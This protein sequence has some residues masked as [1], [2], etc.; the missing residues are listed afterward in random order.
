MK[1]PSEFKSLFRNY[2]FEL[3][4]LEKHC[5]LIVKTVLS[6]GTLEQVKW[7]FKNLGQEEIKKIV[8]EDI[9]GL[10]EMPPRTLNM[11]SLFFWDRE[12]RRSK[13]SRGRKPG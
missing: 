3:L 12:F 4:D 6:R 5:R 8:K 9:E 13:K 1:L 7:L 11:W 2:D 10:Q